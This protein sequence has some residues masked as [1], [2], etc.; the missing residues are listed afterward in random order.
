MKIIR[1]DGKYRN[2]EMSNE[3]G[4]DCWFIS[5]HMTTGFECYEYYI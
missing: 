3:Y 5:S 4:S 2:K 1:E